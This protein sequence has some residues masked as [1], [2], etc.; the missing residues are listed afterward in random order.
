MEEV[1]CGVVG[2]GRVEHGAELGRVSSA[3]YYYHNRV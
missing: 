1:V 2:R 3:S